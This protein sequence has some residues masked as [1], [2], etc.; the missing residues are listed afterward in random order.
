MSYY[1]GFSQPEEKGGSQKDGR[2]S[3]EK[4]DYRKLFALITEKTGWTPQQI[5]ELTIDQ[6]NEY[7]LAWSGG[8]KAST[9]EEY[10]TDNWQLFNLTS[11][12]E[13]VIKKK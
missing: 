8:E 9:E 4:V 11:G 12:L 7:I 10:D 1:A 13:T 5:R 6:I 3:G 2:N